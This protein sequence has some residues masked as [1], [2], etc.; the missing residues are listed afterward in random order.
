MVEIVSLLS[1]P[2]VSRWIKIANLTN[3]NNSERS[4]MGPSGLKNADEKIDVVAPR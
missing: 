1:G 3:E 4:S 2:G